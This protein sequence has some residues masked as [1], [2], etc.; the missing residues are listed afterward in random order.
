MSKSLPLVAGYM[1]L[2]FKKFA[3][4]RVWGLG[5]N[6]SDYYTL[7]PLS[8]TGHESPDPLK[9]SQNPCPHGIFLLGSWWGK[10]IINK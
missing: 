6:L 8:P 1:S 7:A 3:Q 5:G 4:A 10:Q 2:S 9:K